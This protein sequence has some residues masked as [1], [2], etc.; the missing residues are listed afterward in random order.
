MSKSKKNTTV[1][2]NTNMKAKE[3]KMLTQDIVR[4]TQYK[5]GQEVKTNAYLL[6]KLLTDKRYKG[7]PLT[8][9]EIMAKLPFD[10]APYIKLYEC[11]E[12]VDRGQY[13]YTGTALDELG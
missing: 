7:R 3:N 6:A 4:K 11:F 2:I 5:N 10:P 13:V 9:K 8:R 1:I 12:A